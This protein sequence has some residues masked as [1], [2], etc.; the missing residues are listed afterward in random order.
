MTVRPLQHPDQGSMQLRVISGRD[1]R[2]AF[3]AVIWGLYTL[4]AVIAF[5]ALIYMRTAV[6]E[7]S[8][9]L[10]DLDNRIEVAKARQHQLHLEKMRLESPTEI[11]PI[12]E[13][14]LGMV[15]PEEVVAITSEVPSGFAP[16]D[17]QGLLQEKVGG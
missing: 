15:L 13:Q 2:R 8:F 7:S 12:A 9:R 16:A 11:L 14:M 1:R 4:G 17:Y 6:D 3:R 10:N 5:L